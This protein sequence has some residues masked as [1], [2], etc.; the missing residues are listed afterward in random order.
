M[1]LHFVKKMSDQF[2]ELMG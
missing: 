2:L 1:F